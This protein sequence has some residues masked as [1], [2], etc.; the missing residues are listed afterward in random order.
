MAFTLVTGGFTVVASY[1][2]AINT[3]RRYKKT[4]DDAQ[5]DEGRGDT[6]LASSASTELRG[7][8]SSALYGRKIS[9]QQG[10]Q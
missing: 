10:S 5:K 2:L 1:I 3:K 8:P 7:L 6:D 4:I 9:G